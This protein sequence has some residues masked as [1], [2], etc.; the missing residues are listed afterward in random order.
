MSLNGSQET[1]PLRAGIPI[2][3]TIAG[4]YAAFGILAA[5]RERDKTGRGQEVQCAMVDGLISM[6]TFASAVYFSTGELPPRNGNDHMVVSPYGLFQAS[7]GPLAVAPSTLKTWASLCRV[8]DLEELLEDPRFATNDLRRE[9]RAELNRIIGERIKTGTREQWIEKLNAAGVPTGPVNNLDQAF[10]D[11]Q[12][13]HQEMI[14]E[15]DQPSGP[16]G[17]TGFPVKLSATPARI[18]RPSPQTGEHSQ[19]ILREL[20]YGEE[21]IARLKEAKVI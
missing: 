10:N 8:L 19:E 16:V 12:V 13:A 15:S 2:S 5:L 3:D 11:P 14:L 1:D 6:F 17:M 18:R 4:L 9:K 7:D 21:E 20:G